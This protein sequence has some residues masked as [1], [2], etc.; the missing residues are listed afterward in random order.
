MTL[1]AYV[2]A[3]LVLVTLIN[4]YG[5]ATAAELYPTKPIR[6]ILPYP[7]GGSSDMLGRIT[8]QGLTDILGQQVIVDNRPGADGIIAYSTTS[9]SQADGH[10]IA[11]IATSFSINPSLR[12]LPYDPIKSFTAIGNAAIVSN[13]IAVHPAVPVK[14]IS[15][16][17]ALAQKN[18]GKLNFGASGTGTISA[19][20]MEL[21]KERAKINIVLIPYKGTPAMIT[22]L[23][24]GQIDLT[25]NT[26]PGL[27]PYI[28]NQQLRA[29]AVAGSTRS[30]VLPNVPTI[31]ESGHPGFDANTWYGIIGP[32]GIAKNRIGILNTTIVK[33]LNSSTTSGLLLK[34]GFEVNTSTPEQFSEV[35]KLEIAKWGAVVKS[36]KPN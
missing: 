23:V 27:L 34:S 17:V 19:L 14:S 31:A 1:G 7:A 26:L 4:G 36:S 12:K 9:E 11:M 22:D 33:V 5:S 8:A 29:I 10:T 18:P 25:F 21:L 28:R 24:G 16:L 15:D 30:K 35:I 3:V 6:F 2:R 13:V 20:G 32:A